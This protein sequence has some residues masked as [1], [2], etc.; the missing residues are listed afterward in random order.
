MTQRQFRILLMLTVLAGFLGGAGCNLLLRSTPPVAQAAVLEEV[1]A[2]KFVL[3]DDAGKPR[4]LL[5]LVANGR[6]GLALYDGAGKPGIDLIVLPDGGSAL[7]LHD[8]ASNAAVGLTIVPDGGPGLEMYDAAGHAVIGLGVFPDGR[9]VLEMCDAAGT[10]SWQ[11][12]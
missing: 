2:K 9:P 7:T 3:V 5:G 8:A 6:S 12:P 1:F 11:A 10:V 4:A